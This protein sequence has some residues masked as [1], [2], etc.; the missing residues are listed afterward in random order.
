MARA[1]LNVLCYRAAV[2]L[3][4][5]AGTCE[6]VEVAADL[7]RVAVAVNSGQPGGG[8]WARREPG[9][10]LAHDV[11]RLQRDAV[12]NQPWPCSFDR[13]VDHGK[14]EALD[15]RRHQRHVCMPLT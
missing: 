13:R 5:D 14:V 12:R 1:Y 2:G 3:L 11:D 4:D 15:L 7:A 8:D 9:A 10:Q 6:S